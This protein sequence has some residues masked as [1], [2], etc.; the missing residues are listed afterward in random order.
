MNRKAPW[1]AAACLAVSGAAS[2]ELS[3]QR[4]TTVS[5]DSGGSLVLQTQA[6]QSLAAGNSTTTADFDSF[7]PRDPA[8]NIDGA[9]TRTRSRS[10]E[11]MVAVYTGNFTLSATNS[12]GEV[13]SSQWEL[14]DFTVTRE[15]EGPEF[16][17][18]VTIDGTSHTAETLSRSQARQLRAVLA[19]MHFD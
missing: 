11:S 2:A 3:I 8:R 14:T 17:G 5:D 18:S 16:G 4:S 1:L 10:D 7:S 6:S 12:A 19:L 13:Q 9:I 15:G